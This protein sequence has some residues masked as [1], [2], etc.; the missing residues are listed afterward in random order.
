MPKGIFLTC[1]HSR[2]LD[3]LHIF[4]AKVERTNNGCGNVGLLLGKIH[5]ASATPPGSIFVSILQPLPSE[6][7]LL[8]TFSVHHKFITC[9]RWTVIKQT[10]NHQPQN[11]LYRALPEKT[12][13]FRDRNISDMLRFIFPTICQEALVFY[14]IVLR[15]Q[16]LGWFLAFGPKGGKQ[17]PSK[18]I[19]KSEPKPEPVISWF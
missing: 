19:Q 18:L 6:S 15:P 13:P 9:V 12:Y 1:Y 3:F 7:G 4:S 16:I 14:L 5:V 10:A 2:G 11:G 8:G 17:S